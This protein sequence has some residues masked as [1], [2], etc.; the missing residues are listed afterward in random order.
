[1]KHRLH[2]GAVLAASILILPF[3]Q[4]AQ[5]ADP[6][7]TISLATWGSSPSET[8]ALKDA[9]AT[10]EA[11]YPTIKVDL[12]V[13]TDHG[14]QMAAKFASH[15]PPDVFYLG[16][17]VAQDWA[18]QGV[19][20][21]LMPSIASTSFSLDAF[22]KSYL[23][24]FQVG[25]ALYAL[26]KDANPLV[27]EGNMT[28]MAK[29]GIKKLPK[30]TAEFDAQAKKF[31]K[32]KITP[33]CVDA[34][35]NRLGAYFVAFGGGIADASG[36]N[37]LL[38]SAGTKAAMNWVMN[39][40]KTGA[41]RTPAQLSAGWAGEA[42]G[43]SKCAYT[44]EGA[45]LDPFLKDSFPDVSKVMIKAPLPKAK[46]AGSLA[47]TAGYAIGKESAHPAQAWTFISYMTGVRGMTVW[48][49]YGV[50]L[51]SRSDVVT[52]L[53]Y[54]VNGAVAKLATTVTTPAFVG[55]GKVIDAFNNEAKKQI[56]DKKFVPAKAAAAVLAAASAAWPA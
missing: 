4:A 42:F 32:K 51:P 15:T 46:Q 20:L 41:F 26:P 39:N 21:D 18:S 30:T 50:A 33:M 38:K 6:V 12:I 22:N 40:Y 14:A 45:W 27:L 2:V 8:A 24:P 34:D 16:A 37:S 53:G 1:M 31:L 36:K 28:L 17:D 29:A 13:D 10:F 56:Q 44:M 11:R 54:G 19:L 25:S 23:K 9:V 48:T 52:P 35:I 3:A 49:S 5:A 7:T 47:F 43:K 55:W